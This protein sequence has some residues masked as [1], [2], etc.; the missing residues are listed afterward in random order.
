[1]HLLL[2]VTYGV[3][4]YRCHEHDR[5]ISYNHF[6]KKNIARFE[7]LRMAETEHG[8]RMKKSSLFFE[9]ENELAKEKFWAR[10]THA[11]L[12]CQGDL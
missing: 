4:V 1:M 10:P 2:H 5:E 9:K 3:V 11:P 6:F 12:A 8:L 7:G